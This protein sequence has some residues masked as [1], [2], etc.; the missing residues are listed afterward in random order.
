M[1]AISQLIESL[2]WPVAAF[3]IAWI[4]RR[5]ARA[6]IG[7]IEKARLPGGTE[8][9]FGQLPTDRLTEIMLPNS[10]DECSTV[11]TAQWDRFAN[12]YWLGND[13][14][15]T[16]S[17]I[18]RDGQVSSISHGLKQTLHHLCETGLDSTSA[19]KSI[20]GIHELVCD[21]E[22]LSNDERKRIA[23]RLTKLGYEIG[24]IDSVNQKD[25]KPG[26]ETE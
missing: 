12:I 11:E 17:T 3:G 22:Q 15:W 18:L 6:A 26:N 13:L 2:A 5:E 25:Y 16:V 1:E 8:F 21:S 20:K 4:V 9:A 7:R 24:N 10:N 19:G 23:S 14:M